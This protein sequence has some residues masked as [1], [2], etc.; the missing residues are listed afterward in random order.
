MSF[1]ARGHVSVLGLA[2]GEESR[3]DEKAL[4]GICW[5]RYRAEERDEVVVSRE[6]RRECI[7]QDG[8]GGGGVGNRGREA[9][10][11]DDINVSQGAESSAVWRDWTILRG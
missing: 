1:G 6:R 5:G 8:G 3:L 9:E 7:L 2:L 10:G 4:N 11:G